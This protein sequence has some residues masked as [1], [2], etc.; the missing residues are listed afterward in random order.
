MTEVWILVLLWFVVALVLGLLVGRFLRGQPEDL[1][2]V[3][4]GWRRNHRKPD[5]EA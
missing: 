3:S 4:E 1:G 2:S 5:V